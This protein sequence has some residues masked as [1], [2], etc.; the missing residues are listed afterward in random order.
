MLAGHYAAAFVA[1]TVEPKLPFWTLFIA[2]VLTDIAS[3]LLTLAGVERVS[4]D[5][6]LPSNPLVADYIPYTHSLLANALW[7]LLAGLAAWKY[8]GGTRAAVVIAATVFVHW[9]FDLPMH[10]NDLTLAGGDNKLGWALWNYPGSALALEF[11]VIIA[12]VLLYLLWVKPAA[13]QRKIAITL[14]VVL[15][16]VQVYAVVAPPPKTVIELVLSLLVT[17]LALAG[18]SYWLERRARG[19]I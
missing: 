16:G 6:S 5:F 13:A 15:A 17:F 1:K 2:A 9:F 8:L 18:L 19:T 4:L 11:G 14:G 3:S 12:S 7:A 10:R